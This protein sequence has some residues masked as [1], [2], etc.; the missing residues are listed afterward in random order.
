MDTTGIALII[1]GVASIA[2]GI[3]GKFRP[4]IL[5]RNW[6]GKRSFIGGFRLFGFTPARLGDE[7]MVPEDKQRFGFVCFVLF[8]VMI[9]LVGIVTSIPQW[10]TYK[11]AIT[12]SIV[13]AITIMM[14][15]SYWKIMLS[16]N[17]RFKGISFAIVMLLS[18]ALI[19]LAVYNWHVILK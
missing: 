16:Q 17:E 2:V 14:L 18:F 9:I 12:I 5:Y 7:K 8:G 6:G 15:F 1:M 13:M 3:F 10:E 11:S 4:D 19:A